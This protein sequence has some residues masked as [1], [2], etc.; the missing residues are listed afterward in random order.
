ME[1]ELPHSPDS[2]ASRPLADQAVAQQPQWTSF[3]SEARAKRDSWR[4]VSRLLQAAVDAAKGSRVEHEQAM[5]AELERVQRV[6]LGT[7]RHSLSLSVVKCSQHQQATHASFCAGLYWE[8]KDAAMILLDELAE[9]EMLFALNTG[10]HHLWDASAKRAWEPTMGL[11]L[12][13]T[14]LPRCADSRDEAGE[15]SH[16]MLASTSEGSPAWHKL[17]QQVNRGPAIAVIELQ[18]RFE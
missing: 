5:A 4:E 13:N 17:L 8:N 12:A 3:V 1:L 9:V 18:W 16:G 11:L 10:P 14:I 6:L 15:R 7:C 2:P